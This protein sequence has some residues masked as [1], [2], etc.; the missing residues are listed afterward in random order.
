MFGTKSPPT[1]LQKGG[2]RKNRFFYGSL[3]MKQRLQEHPDALPLFEG[4]WGDFLSCSRTKS[5]KLQTSVD[6]D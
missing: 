1:P 2:R 6:K 5:D 4:G 3:L